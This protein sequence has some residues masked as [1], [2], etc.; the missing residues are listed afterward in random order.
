MTLLGLRGPRWL[1]ADK[2]WR[3]ATAHVLTEVKLQEELLGV[4]VPVHPEP[5]L[6]LVHL[7]TRNLERITKHKLYKMS[8]PKI[9]M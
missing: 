5:V 1:P 8:G 2:V 7:S 3:R 6:G 9:K 4:A